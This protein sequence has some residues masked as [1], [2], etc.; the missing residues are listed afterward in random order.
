[1]QTQ[2]M[3]AKIA[4][5]RALAD[6][7]AN[8]A[9]LAV[10]A[11][12][13]KDFKALVLAAEKTTSIQNARLRAV[14]EDEAC[15]VE[16]AAVAGMG[17]FDAQIMD[18]FEVRSG[19]MAKDEAVA[20]AVETTKYLEAKVTTA[21]AATARALAGVD[22]AEAAVKGFKAQEMEKR[23]AA[24]QVMVEEGAVA[25]A[26]AWKPRSE[27]PRSQRPNKWRNR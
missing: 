18:Y 19:E 8:A 15:A 20:A 25:A 16:A 27:H 14:A 24:T 13:A 12:T 4:R 7:Y 21:K 17:A 5:S 22:V 6:K 3:L 2:V 1:M 10:S 11:T 26:A 23:K 9:V